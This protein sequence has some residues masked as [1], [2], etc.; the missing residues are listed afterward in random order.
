MNM[1]YYFLT[2]ISIQWLVLVDEIMNHKHVCNIP[3]NNDVIQFFDEHVEMLFLET[4]NG[5]LYTV[6]Q[7]KNIYNINTNF[8]QYTGIIEAIKQR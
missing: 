7:F 4:Q 8:L 6:A 1:E 5:E 2:K 3:I